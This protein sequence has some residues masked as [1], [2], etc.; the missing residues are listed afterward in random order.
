[1]TLVATVRTV[2]VEVV[3]RMKIKESN[4]VRCNKINRRRLDRILSYDE[5]HRCGG[6]SSGSDD[7]DARPGEVPTVDDVNVTEWLADACIERVMAV[8]AKAGWDTGCV[9]VRSMMALFRVGDM[10]K[11]VSVRAWNVEGCGEGNC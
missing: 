11:D 5:K 7:G 9:L 8:V 10:W 4:Q 3:V 1:M 6:D 2:V